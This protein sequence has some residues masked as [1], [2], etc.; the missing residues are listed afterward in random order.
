MGGLCE[1]EGLGELI[2]SFTLMVDTLSGV[3]FYFLKRLPAFAAVLCFGSALAFGAD[4][5]SSNLFADGSMAEV[6][7]LNST[8]R[9]RS[10]FAVKASS[11]ISFSAGETIFT[12]WTAVASQY[13]D[14]YV[15]NNSS[16]GWQL[17]VYTDNF[18][19]VS[20]STTIWGYQ[21]G[22]L[23]GDTVSGARIPMGWLVRKSTS[24]FSADPYFDGNPPVLGEDPS[25]STD[26]CRFGWLHLK[27]LSDANP[28]GF[29]TYS[30]T[31]SAGYTNVAYGGAGYTSV[32]LPRKDTLS[33]GLVNRM[34][35]FYILFEADF[36]G[37]YADT[38][39]GIIKLDM[40]SL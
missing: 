18:N 13:L 5:I 16:A 22:G 12:T 38:Y 32:V 11:I 21:Y 24:A 14:I 6:R 10:T 1:H 3:F 34:D 39:T 25:I 8:L 33:W 29:T 26:T 31:G 28:P 30:F 17:K 23:K 7:D 4:K 37:A 27:D 36:N 9:E 19:G 40:I 15:V 2:Y 35:H 20:I